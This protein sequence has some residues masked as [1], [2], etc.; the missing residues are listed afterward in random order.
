[1]DYLAAY[2]TADEKVDISDLKS[3]LSSYLTSYMVPQAFMQL[4]EMPMNLS[5]KIDKKALPQAV[6]MEDEI[7]P[8]ENETQEQI[9]EIVKEVIGDLPLGITSD[10]FSFGLSS[11]G[12]IKLCA[13]LSEHFGRTLKVS[14][15]FENSTVKAI[16]SIL[17]NADEEK[18][19]E[20]RE[21]YPLSMTQTGIYIECMRYPGSTI[22]N[23]PELHKLGDS[24]D[25]EKLAKAIEKA[26]AA[27]P[28]L[29]MEPVSDKDGIVHARRRDDYKFETPVFKKDTIPTEDELVRPFFLD[30][31]EVLFRAEIYET[32][33]GNYFFLDTHHIVSDGGSLDILKRDIDRAYSGE[34]IEK[35]KYTGYEFALDEEAARKSERFEKAKAWY[36]GYFAGCGGETLPV[37]D[38]KEENGHIGFLKIIAE[39]DG[40]MIRQFCLD[41]SYTLNAFFTTAFGLAL[42]SYTASENAIFT[43]IYNGRSDGRLSD[44][45]SMLVKTLPVYL[46]CAPEKKVLETIEACQKYI[47]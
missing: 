47:L 32:K 14:D 7:V 34:E 30:T 2:F 1:T 42:K 19:Y 4:D 45:V 29:F 20:L 8:P 25:C 28:Y 44:S 6:M 13:L 40:A 22:Y 10:L 18:E 36:D 23:I 9:L 24:V 43:T 5:G 3:Y 39:T 33:N 27:H 41:N 31:G 12:C 38:G 37:K 46:E 11:V 16:D 35:E 17:R 26:V 15:V 21:E